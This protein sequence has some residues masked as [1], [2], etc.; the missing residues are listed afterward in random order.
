VRLGPDENA[1]R[2]AVRLRFDEEKRPIP[3]H[4]GVLPPV[5][6]QG[7]VEVAVRR[8][9]NPQLLLPRMRLSAEALPVLKVRLATSLGVR[10]ATRQEP[11]LSDRPAMKFAIRPDG[12]VHEYSFD[13][14][15]ASDGRWSGTVYW[16]MLSFP[17]NNRQGE[18]I[19]VETVAF[20]P[21][22]GP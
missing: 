11:T 20:E 13:L 1:N 10:F 9:G 22:A 4:R 5:Y 15:Q 16:V 3:Y 2:E 6:S 8:A 21:A 17:D 12:R 7:G 18:R 19:R 14:R